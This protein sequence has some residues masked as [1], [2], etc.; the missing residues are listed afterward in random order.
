M[1]QLMQGKLTWRGEEMTNGSD[2]ARMRRLAHETFGYHDL[3][4]AQEEVI[5]AVLGGQDTLA[6]MPT[7]SGKSATYQIAGLIRAG[8]TV[9]ISP[10]LALQQDQVEKLAALEIGQAL[11]LN[12][13]LNAAERESVLADV[14]SGQCRFL[15]T[16]PEQF[17]H[18]ETL[19]IVRQVKPTLFVVDEAHCISDWGEDFR[20]DFLRLGAVIEALGHPT[21]LALTATAS[22][23]VREDI[24]NR[25]GMRDP[26]IAI[27][28]FDRPN[29]WLGVEDFHDETVK[30][31]EL[32][33]R[34]AA[35]PKPGIV[36]VATRKHAEE[37]AA[38]L[39]EMEQRSAYYHAGMPSH[40]RERVQD[41]FMAGEIDVLAATTA[42][43]LGVDKADIRFVF[44][45][46][47]PDSI[48]SYY[49]EI[50][51]AGRDGDP[52]T[53]IL[54]YRSGDL[55]I[56]QF[57]AGGGQVDEEQVIEVL[58]AVRESNDAISPGE[59]REMTDLSKTKLATALTRLE[60][61]GAVEIEPTGEVTETDLRAEPAEIAEE[62]VNDEKHRLITERSRIDMMRGYAETLHCRR[63]YILN[64]F[65]EAFQAP[66]GNCDNDDRGAPEPVS[67]GDVPF[68]LGSRVIHAVFGTGEVER[69]EDDSM[70]VLFDEVGYKTLL[71]DFVVSSDALQ[72]AGES[73]ISE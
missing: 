27:Q 38:D 13:N 21:V 5:H 53:A 65:G 61:A 23:L 45:H 46:D 58:D 22:S 16:A 55:T 36:Y 34:T 42:F 25:L 20:P 56:H 71:T 47:I 14:A 59:I 43:G 40:E 19:E 73:S 51:R 29:I 62:V 30:R 69:Y 10:L 2:T 60:D 35:A 1:P 4:A 15:F 26:Y 52:A 49:Q 7:G 28:G 32:L 50:G 37:V 33:A 12:S 31:R 9:V 39:E 67:K 18:T 24:V 70:T 41:A 44:H 48:D 6:V 63:A 68:A 11:V 72:L 57:F 8:L 66:C 64:Y 3:S 54:F 17:H